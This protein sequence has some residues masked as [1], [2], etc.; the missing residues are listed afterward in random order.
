MLKRLETAGLVQRTRNPDNERQVFVA[1]TA[2]GR[3]LRAKAGC[4]GESLLTASG[5]SPE[6]LGA[7]NGKIRKLRDAI[8]PSIGGWDLTRS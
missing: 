3:E 8:Y 5:Q 2:K 4:L 6:Q 7:L 1:L